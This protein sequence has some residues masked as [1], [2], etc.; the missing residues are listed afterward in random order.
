MK[1]STVLKAGALS[2]IQLAAALNIILTNDDAYTSSNIRAT[3]QAL[4]DEG[5]NVF[6]V[7]PAENQ[8]GKGGT[9]SFSSS[10]KLQ[11]SSEFGDLP[12]GSP[13]WGYEESDNHVWYFNG[14]PAAS[15][16]FGLDYVIP[17]YFS[18]I[19]IDLVVSGPNEGSNAGPGLFTLSGTIGAT[20]YA[21][22]RGIPAAAFSADY[23]NHSYY[24][25]VN[26]FLP[27]KDDDSF[28]SNIYAKTVVAKLV[29]ALATAAGDN[30][31]L[32]PLGV[33]LNI[34]IPYVGAPAKETYNVDCTAPPLVYT[35]ITGGAQS[36]TVKFNETSGVFVWSYLDSQKAPGL[37]VAYNGPTDLAGETDVSNAAGCRVAVSAYSVDYTAP[38]PVNDEVHNLIQAALKR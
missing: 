30:D 36:Y 6:I 32:L 20:Y 29:D 19:N 21:V 25:D 5:H 9:F 28:Y 35:R 17:N 34:N 8:S 11:K 37:N 33:G 24:K 1:F 10:P 31:R 12:A 14:T 22:G 23:S 3:Y 7:A 16:A 13:A 26:G 27:N 18:N 38:A 2:A 15:V 4:K